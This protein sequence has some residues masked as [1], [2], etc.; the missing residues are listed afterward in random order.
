VTPQDGR[1]AGSVLVSV[2]ALR[3][4][5]VRYAAQASVIAF[6]VLV[7]AGMWGGLALQMRSER[8]A[9]IEAAHREG[10]NYARI[11]E[12]HVTRTLHEVEIV[13]A[14][15]DTEYRRLGDRLDLVGMASELHVSLDPYLAL[16]VI[17]DKGDL[18]RANYV[19]QGRPN[20]RERENFRF[21][22]AHDTPETFISQ[23]RRAT[24]GP[25]TDRW[26]IIVSRRMS[27]PDGGFAG[28]VSV[29]MDPFYFS[30][31]YS[32][33]DLGRGSIVALVGRDGVIRARQEDEG[34]SAAQDVSGSALFQSIIRSSGEGRLVG[35]GQL[36]T[37]TRLYSYRAVRNYPLI[38]LVGRSEEAVLAHY[39]ARRSAYL[40]WAGGAT[41]LI[42]LFA[43]LLVYQI[44]HRGRSEARVRESE[45]RYLELVEQASDG[46]FIA[47]ASGRYLQFNEAARAMLGFTEEELRAMSMRDLVPEEDQRREPLRIDELRAGKS[48]L[49]ERR[50]LRKDGGLLPVEISARKLGNGMLQ[51]VVRDVS[52]RKRVEESLRASEA[53]LKEAQALAKLGN[54]ELDLVGGK[55]TWSDE[56]YRIFEL[57]PAQFGASYEAFLK[58]IHPDDRESVNRVY[59]ASVANRTSYAIVH[60][61][62][63]SDG[64]IKHVQERGQTFYAEDG[65]PLR[66]VGTVQDVT[67]LHEAEQAL[68][69]LNAELEARVEA[70]TA[71]LRRAN[72]T[73]AES[74][75]ELR[76]AQVR[77]V[78]SEKMAA[79][80]SLVAGIAHEI[81]TPLGIGV[82]AASHVEL[83][84]RGL[85]ERFARGQPTR[86][87]MEG[88]LS[89]ASEA[90][91]MVLANL[92][93]AAD[94]IRSFKQVAVDQSSG[95]R[96]TFSLK[97]YLD[98]VLLSL[99]PQLRR[100][101]HEVLLV[102]P[103]NLEI[104]SYPGAYS[105]IVT[106]LVLNSLTHGFDGIEHGRIEIEVLR[107]G[108]SL[109]LRYRDNGR[110]IAPEHLPKIFDPFFTTK[111]GLG[112]SGL[113][114]HVLY[115][116]VTQTLG[117][118][119]GC[120]SKPGEGASFDIDLP[121]R[122]PRR[123]PA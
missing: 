74:L 97:P 64:R 81:N 21:H 24:S 20:F 14:E 101:R 108:E 44:G 54:W 93:R 84:V 123:T 38:V 112:G 117:G 65:K 111:R 31:L 2:S 106:N 99:G 13:L 114:L 56:I 107:E 102:C 43:A 71:E 78:Q 1:A 95:E 42:A 83:T 8:G 61:L 46:I 36:A 75:E 59:T 120:R 68:R 88:F 10:G 98:E 63:M 33:V 96:R 73:L 51:A 62:R 66:S 6:C 34:Q 12:E 80:G 49:T 40:S 19:I 89:S 90:C 60:R 109:R 22:A 121:L 82:T 79:L 30:Q 69:A 45:Q 104:D 29:V 9:I 18:K 77:L 50:L 7:I 103:E 100:T 23:P 5:L 39:T 41:L 70:R 35:R 47:D 27:R 105:Q 4:L 48:L 32:K 72:S 67:A 110:G 115:N 17:D 26:S 118:T 113:G 85:R 91:E 58:A 122:P 55:L 116:L 87:E 94:L 28:Y 57:D 16:A 25:N 92:Q 52:A 86:Q 37:M 15:I 119:I 53:R 76:A 11:L 3:A